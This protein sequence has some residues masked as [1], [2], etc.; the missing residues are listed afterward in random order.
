[1]KEKGAAIIMA[2]LIVAVSATLAASLAWREGIFAR[3][4]ENDEERTDAKWLAQAGTNF[5]AAVLND[6]ARHNIVDYQGEAWATQLPAMPV[7]NG[8]V[9]G[10]ITDQQ[11]LFNLNNLALNGKTD[12]AHLMQFRALLSLLGIQPDLAEA[13]ADWIDSDS[14][15][16]S[17]GGA[18]NSYYLGLP[19][20]YRAA[21]MPFA[22]IDD[23]SLVKGFDEATMERLKPY[24]TVLP[25]TTQVNVNTAPPEVLAAILPGLSLSRANELVNRR[26]QHYFNDVADFRSAIPDPNVIIQDN[27]VEVASQYF[28]VTVN[29]RQGKSRV[30][31]E[32][33][34]DREGTAWPRAVWHRS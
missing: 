25:N 11:G 1:M 20:P 12:V 26:N 17:P 4:L 29:A 15:V 32:T 23:L 22:E 8:E 2:I 24:V 14:A 10:F 33:L 31:M 21:N 13:V 5:A 27:Q 3:R 6:D 16:Q 19:D 9:S 7:E 34:L 18:E 28:L 30:T